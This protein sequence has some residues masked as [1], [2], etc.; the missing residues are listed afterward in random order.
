[1]AYVSKEDK[2]ARMPAIRAA[3][4]KHGMQGSVR[5]ENYSKLIVT[6]SKGDLDLIDFDLKHRQHKN[7]FDDEAL[8]ATE[9]RDHYVVH[10]AGFFNAAEEIGQPEVAELFS[11]LLSALKGDDYFDESE[12]M[13]DYSHC[14]HYYEVH[15]GRWNKPFE[16]TGA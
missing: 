3:L 8:V 1:M 10:N 9:A 12:T 4:K 6:I 5:V 2:A 13:I 7:R 11:E 14:S 16:F 15:V